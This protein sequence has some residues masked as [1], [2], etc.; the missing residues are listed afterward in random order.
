MSDVVFS[1]VMS[2]DLYDLSKFKYL[3]LEKLLV[4][5]HELMLMTMIAST[6]LFIVFIFLIFVWSKIRC[7]KGFIKLNFAGEPFIC[8]FRKWLVGWKGYVLLGERF[9]I[10]R[11]IGN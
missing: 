4:V 8:V 9:G 3:L 6:K 7:F 1:G 11:H 10:V 2:F 5:P